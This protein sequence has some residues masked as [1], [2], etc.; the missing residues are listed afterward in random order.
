MY[1]LLHKHVARGGLTLT[2]LPDSIGGWKFQ[3][4]LASGYVSNFH[5]E[6]K[7]ELIAFQNHIHEQALI[8]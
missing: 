5:R 2:L 6:K 7:T 3:F 1:H 8:L 4:Q